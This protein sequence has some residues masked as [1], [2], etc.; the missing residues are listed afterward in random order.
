MSFPFFVMS[1]QAS[2]IADDLWAA[3]KRN[4]SQIFKGAGTVAGLYGASSASRLTDIGT[5]M[6]Q[7]A[8]ESQRLQQQLVSSEQS[9]EAARNLNQTL[10]LQRAMMGATGDMG[11]QGGAIT[12]ASQA[13]FNADERARQLS[14]TFGQAQIENQKRLLAVQGASQKA[15]IFGNLFATTAQDL[16]GLFSSSATPLS[17]K[18]FNVS[19]GKTGHIKWK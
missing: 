3:A 7:Q 5:R 17:G 8:L 16:G 4:K 12:N 6:D 15:S 13:A 1:A 19:A 18:G 10:S 2:G 11:P 9:L 14:L